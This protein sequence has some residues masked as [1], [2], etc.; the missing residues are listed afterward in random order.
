MKIS[1]SLQKLVRPIAGLHED[2][3][4]ARRH[5]E[6]NL[7]AIAT[8]LKT[9]GQQKPIVALRDGRI[10]AGN[11]TFRAARKLGWKSLAVAYFESSGKADARAYAIADN[12]TGELALWDGRD[13]E[14][15]LKSLAAEGVDI[16]STLAFTEKEINT[17]IRTLGNGN[18]VHEEA[19]APRPP[20]K[21]ATKRG[22]VWQMGSHRLICGDASSAHDLLVLLEGAVIHLVNTDPPYNVR[23]EPRSNNAI[24]AGVSSYT[25]DKK[26][27]AALHHQQL[28]LARHPGKAKATHKQMR[29]KDRPLE[30]DF[31][32]DREFAEKLHNWFLQLS[33]A[34][35]PGRAFYIWGGYS[36]F[37][38]Y[39]AAFNGTELYFSQGI[40]WVK[41][42]PVLTRKDFMGNHEWCFYGWRAG[43]PHKFYGPHNIPDV[44]TVKK[45]NP[46][47][48]VHLT[49]KP[50]ELARRA[51]EYSSRPNEN[52]LD[53]FGGSGSTLM[54]CEQLGRRG[55][56]LELDPA[57]CDV[58][59]DRWQRQTDKKA[60]NL[61]RKGVV[62]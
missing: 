39:A 1:T 19:P 55:F 28:D 37:F 29:A 25:P 2:K 23:V 43:G 21:A 59:V 51:I 36:N 26:R 5:N 24:S 47:K 62:I 4:N 31:I 46:N 40:V 61:K 48:M 27:R 33:H 53:L 15:T 56:L 20:K 22:D 6:R 18:E 42:H 60:V 30:N 57:Y 11:G 7:K 12:R 34:L 9:F 16:E 38:N 13:L 50:V 17:I 10:I 14:A 41:E 3:K 52:V 58:I 45:V 35:A 49:E 44:W 54:A 8:S 32:S